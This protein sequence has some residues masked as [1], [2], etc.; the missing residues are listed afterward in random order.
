MQSNQSNEPQEPNYETSRLDL[1]SL[2]QPQ[3][4][5]HAWRQQGTALVCESCPFSHASY[6][7]MGFQLYGI[8]EDGQPMIRRLRADVKDGLSI[9]RVSTEP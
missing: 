8:S 3:L 4:T 1:D 7:P 5:G 6:L 9:P 2:P